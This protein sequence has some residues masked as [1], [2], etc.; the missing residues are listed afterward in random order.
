MKAS[1]WIAALIVSSQAA[2]ANNALTRLDDVVTSETILNSCHLFSA[3]DAREDLSASDRVGKDAW[4]LILAA[5]DDRDSAHHDDNSRKADF[6]LQGRIELDQAVAQKNVVE[7]GCSALVPQ[8]RVT[9]E[10]LHEK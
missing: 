4:R 9:L 7:Q 2:R 10:T 1:I 5:L 6:L 8:A 3:E